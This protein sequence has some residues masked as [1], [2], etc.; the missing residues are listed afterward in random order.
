MF[1]PSG[2]RLLHRPGPDST[3]LPFPIRGGLHDSSE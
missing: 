1:Q 3:R 2:L